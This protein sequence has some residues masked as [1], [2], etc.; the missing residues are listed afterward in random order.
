MNL[1]AAFST[2]EMLDALKDQVIFDDDGIRETPSYVTMARRG[3]YD[4]RAHK[5]LE[6]GAEYRY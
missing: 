1:Q 6:T 4:P 5:D 3:Q 2:A